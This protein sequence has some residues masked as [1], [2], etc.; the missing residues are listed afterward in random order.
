M[1][2]IITQYVNYRGKQVLVSSLKPKSQAVVI[3]RCKHGERKVRWSRINSWCFK[4]NAESGAYNTSSKGR[5]ITWGEKIS[6]A[7]KG[8]K[9]SED[10]K[11]ALSIAQYR[12]DEQNWPGF[13]I[14]GEIHRLRDSFEFVEAKKRVLKRDSFTCQVTGRV[15]GRLDI[16]HIV[17]VST[18]LSKA[19]EL[20]NMVVLTKAVHKEFH[21]L[22]GRGRN[23]LEQF[24]DFLNNRYPNSQWLRNHSK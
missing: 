24:V 11:K 13:Y 17:G 4:C 22:Y 10:H 5:T 23:T 19:L 12:C 20:E 2:C 6:K 7:K 15:G 18:D 21:D 3:V 8:R 16:H 14:K 9:F 1:N